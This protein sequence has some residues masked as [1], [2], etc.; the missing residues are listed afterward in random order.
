MR[1]FEVSLN[2]ERLC[3]AGIDGDGS[4]TAILHAVTAKPRDELGLEVQ[5]LV[6]AT[7]EYVKWAQVGLKVGDEVRVRIVE[8]ASADEPKTRKP[9][10]LIETE[11]MLEEKKRYLREMAKKLG[12][13]LTE[14]PNLA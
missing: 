10:R 14:P 4:L 1:V 3:A 13:T 8:S 12:W 7:E 2:G 6:S 11:D 9:A 5:G